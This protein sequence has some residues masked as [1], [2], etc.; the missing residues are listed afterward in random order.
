MHEWSARV[1]VSN[2]W[3]RCEMTDEFPIYVLAVQS[4]KNPT[5]PLLV[6][7][8]LVSTLDR[9]R[10]TAEKRQAAGVKGQLRRREGRCRARMVVT[11]VSVTG[12]D[13]PFCSGLKLP[14]MNNVGYGQP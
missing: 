9:A 5:P 1:V 11:S 4:S 10:M 14:K 8:R 12:P 6:H 13:F 3:P 2:G 7:G